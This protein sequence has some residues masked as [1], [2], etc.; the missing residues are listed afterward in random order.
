MNHLKAGDCCVCRG[1]V[2][3]DWTFCLAEWVDGDSMYLGCICH[4]CRNEIMR[5][6]REVLEAVRSVVLK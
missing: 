2:W 6:S 3:S 5:S 4:R 1:P